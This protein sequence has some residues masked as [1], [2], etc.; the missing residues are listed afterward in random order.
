MSQHAVSK[1]CP[2]CGGVEYSRRKPAARVAFASDRECTTCQTRYTPPTPTWA[3]V[4]FAIAG[5]LLAGFGAVG[6]L[7]A[8]ASLAH[9]NVL[10][11]A[12]MVIPACLGFSGFLAVSQGISA[13]RKPGQV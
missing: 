3:G 1:V 4:A 9:G 8:L 7:A 6:M 11:L 13:L 10:G 5:T 12:Q 2:K